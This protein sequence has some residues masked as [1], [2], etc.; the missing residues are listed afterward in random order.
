MLNQNHYPKILS[1]ALLTLGASLPFNAFS[2]EC[3][4]TITEPTTLTEDLICSIS[5]SNTSALTIQRPGGSLYMAGFSLT[6]LGSDPS[7][8]IDLAASSGELS[9]GTINGCNDGVLLSEDGFHTVY[10]MNILLPLEDAIVVDSNSNTVIGNF[11]SGDGNDSDNGIDIDGNYN[12]IS[13]NVIEL[14][15]D[16]GMEVDGIA[17]TIIQNTITGSDDDG[18]ELNG[19]FSIFISNTIQDSIS[20]G[21]VIEGSSCTVSNNT[22]TDNGSSG[23]TLQNSAS[24][25]SIA[26]NTSS[27]ND[28]FGIFVSSNNATGNSIVFNTA[29]GNGVF[30][31]IDLFESDDCSVNNNLWSGNTFRHPIQAALNN[32]LI[33]QLGVV[34]SITHPVI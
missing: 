33:K 16:E 28:D 13:Q 29:T 4:D 3:G 22:V 19:D 23:I 8:G 2:V 12:F 26:Q 30:D 18:V 9:T 20:M 24:N 10:G 6:C 14:S 34:T 15:G 25:N 31:L 32:Y 21:L 1:T 27:D 7:N 5:G 17:N 11:T